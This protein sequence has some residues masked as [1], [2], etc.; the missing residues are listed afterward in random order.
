[1]GPDDVYMCRAC[2]MSMGLGT[3]SL[4]MEEL[5]RAYSAFASGGQLVQPYYIEEV[6]DLNGN[7]LEKHQRVPFPTVITPEVSTITTW[8]LKEVALNGT[9]A[10]ATREL[11][12]PVAGKTGTTDSQKDAWFV[13]YTNELITG[14]W[15]GYEKPKNM[16]AG[17]TG[18]VTALPPWIEYMSHAKKKYANKK[19]PERGQIVWANIDEEKG[20]NVTSGGR[21][22]PFIMGTV[23]ESSG[24]AAGQVTAEDLMEL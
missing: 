19:F 23:P 1:M 21:T 2:D 16:G 5:L 15:I 24:V 8:L 14:T 6:Q 3:S 12:I 18:G 7:T 11:R 17:H 10:R 13:G 20:I 9:A 22:Y 4:T